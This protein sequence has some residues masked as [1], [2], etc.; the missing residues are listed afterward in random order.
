MKISWQILVF[1]FSTIF[2]IAAIVVAIESWQENSVVQAPTETPNITVSPSPSA[3]LEVLNEV[4]V[5][6]RGDG[7]A[8]SEE[9]VNYFY[10]SRCDNDIS[11]CNNY[12]ISK[13]DI[14]DI[15]FAVGEKV[16]I[17]GTGQPLGAAAGNHYFELI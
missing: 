3:I 17:S 8:I 13:N 14:G 11:I 5:E 4:I 12:L 1:T 2:L 10:F 7:S 9:Y 6:Y 16:K 15:T